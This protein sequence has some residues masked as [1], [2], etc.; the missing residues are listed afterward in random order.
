VGSQTIRFDSV[1]EPDAGA[2][3]GGRAEGRPP[4]GRRKGRPRPAHLGVAGLP[5]AH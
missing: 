3:R 4:R 1:T 2:A 5:D